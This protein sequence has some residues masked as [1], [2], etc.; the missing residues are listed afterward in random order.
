MYGEGKWKVRNHV[1]GERRMW[2]KLHLGFDE[3]TGE[4]L[5]AVVT[6]NDMADCEILPDLLEQIAQETCSSI[7]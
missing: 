6:T 3:G 7:R 5:A 2:R 4:I 1:V